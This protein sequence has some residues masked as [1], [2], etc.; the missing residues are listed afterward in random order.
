[1]AFA[2]KIKAGYLTGVS[3]LAARQLV[4]GRRYYIPRMPRGT[5]KE[6]PAMVLWAE[7]I[8]LIEAEGW[9]LH[10]WALDAGDALPLFTRSE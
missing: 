4:E 6:S 8:E 9:I 3:G 7:V 5:Q 10:T 2:D 1:M